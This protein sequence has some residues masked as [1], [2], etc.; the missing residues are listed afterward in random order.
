MAERFEP[1]D[2]DDAIREAMKSVTEGFY[3][4]IGL[5]L[6]Q[7]D[8]AEVPPYADWRERAEAEGDYIGLDRATEQDYLEAK[9]RR[10]Q[11]LP[12]IQSIMREQSQSPKTESENDGTEQEYL[13]IRKLLARTYEALRRLDQ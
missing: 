3:S 9:E 7:A 10:L 2:S 13:E 4:S 1:L 6:P 12:E 11:M 8:Y 5:P